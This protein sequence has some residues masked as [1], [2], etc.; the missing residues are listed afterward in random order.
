MKEIVI[1]D[2]AINKKVYSKFLNRFYRIFIS[3]FSVFKNII[4]ITYINFFY[5]NINILNDKFFFKD[6]NFIN[7]S[8]SILSEKIRTNIFVFYVDS[9]SSQFINKRKNLVNYK[10]FDELEMLNSFCEEIKK[11][12]SFIKI[13]LFTD[14]K[15]FIPK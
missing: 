13:I 15:T 2:P 11:K 7:N 9:K 12:Y 3:L 8:K 14:K 1:I 5:K 6:L 10:K 4:L